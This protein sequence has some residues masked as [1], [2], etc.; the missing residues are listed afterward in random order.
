M[1]ILVDF[2][3]C[4]STTD[5]LP[6]SSPQVVFGDITLDLGSFIS[7]FAGPILD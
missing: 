3:L 2:G 4:W 1:R 7:N 6:V 5:G